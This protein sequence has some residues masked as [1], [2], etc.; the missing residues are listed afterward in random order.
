MQVAAPST[1]LALG[2]RSAAAAVASFLAGIIGFNESNVEIAG[3]GL[4]WQVASK[5]PAEMQLDFAT[6]P[7]GTDQVRASRHFQL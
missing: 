5:S 4:D 3:F 1:L 6:V 7:D 2:G